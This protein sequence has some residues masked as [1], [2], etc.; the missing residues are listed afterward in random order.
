[1]VKGRNTAVISIRLPDDLKNRLRA[2]ARNKHLT[3]SDYIKRDVESLAAMYDRDLD[4]ELMAISGRGIIT[5][6][7][8]GDN[9]LTGVYKIPVNDNR[10]PLVNVVNPP[11]EALSDKYI[12]G[13][14][15]L[16]DI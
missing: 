12:D 4:G 9:N 15:I 7:K 6:S 1:M 14:P 13:E 5:S 16:K 8:I 10:N 3:L 2:K 11:K